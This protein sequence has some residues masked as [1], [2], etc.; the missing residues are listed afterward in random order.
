M[1]IKFGDGSSIRIKKEQKIDFNYSLWTVQQL[2]EECSRKR[3]K[4]VNKSKTYCQAGQ[5]KNGPDH[6]HCHEKDGRK[7][8]KICQSITVEDDWQE[9]KSIEE[10]QGVDGADWR[11]EW[12]EGRGAKDRKYGEEED[13]K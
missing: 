10:I 3:M 12:K 9:E 2:R 11:L 6:H 5:S 8:R 4:G 7:C 1:K 13:L